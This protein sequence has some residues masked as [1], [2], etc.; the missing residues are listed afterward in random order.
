LA[1]VELVTAAS[2]M[3][4]MVR[5]RYFTQL[6]LLVVVVVVAKAQMVLV[7]AREAVLVLVVLVA[8]VE[9]EQPIKALLVATL[10]VQ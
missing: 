2:L 6:P 10:E 1:V 8:S 3:G 4:Q 9:Q 7:V 5:T